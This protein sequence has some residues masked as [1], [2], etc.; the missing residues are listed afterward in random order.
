MIKRVR[1][2]MLSISDLV[3]VVLLFFLFFS[4]AL[5]RLQ[6]YDELNAG[7]RKYIGQRVA[8]ALIFFFFF[9]G[10]YADKLAAGTRN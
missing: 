5:P 3:V 4:Q 1:G 2:L 9:F 6:L 7:L 8:F 10:V